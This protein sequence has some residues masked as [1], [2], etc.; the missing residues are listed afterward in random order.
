MINTS[1]AFAPA[2]VLG[3]GSVDVRPYACAAVRPSL[4]P[5]FAAVEGTRVTFVAMGRRRG[6]DVLAGVGA[7]I[8]ATT[9][10]IAEQHDPNTENDGTTLGNHSPG[11]PQS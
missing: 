5:P 1:I 6:A 7:A 2:G 10:P 8:Q 9:A 4:L 3:S 11:R